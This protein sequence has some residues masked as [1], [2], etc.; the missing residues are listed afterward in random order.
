M[1]ISAIGFGRWVSAP[2]KPDLRRASGA[3]PHRPYQIAPPAR[4]SDLC[5]ANPT[6][7]DMYFDRVGFSLLHEVNPA[8]TTSLGGRVS[9]LPCQVR[10]IPIE[11]APRPRKSDL[12]RPS[13][14]RA[15][16]AIG[17]GGQSPRSDSA[18][19]PSA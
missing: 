6:F 14:R 11:A 4:S 15:G 17:P 19:G 13:G 5:A 3:K 12:R 18:G 1:A 2:R 8:G 9:D 7:V 16:A 10:L